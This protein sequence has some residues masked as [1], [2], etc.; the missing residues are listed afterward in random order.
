MTTETLKDSASTASDAG[1]GVN[2]HSFSAISTFSEVCSLQYRYRYLDRLPQERVS[3]ALVFGTAINAALLSIDKDLAKG[4]PPRAAVAH[5]V[6]RSE[7]EKAYGNRSLPVVSTHGEDLEGLYGKGVKMIDFHV[8]NLIPDEVPVDMPRRFT[9]P[10]LDEKGEA[11]PRPLV[12][13]LDRVVRLKDGSYGIVDWKTASARWSHDRIAK[14]DQATVYLL[15]G[16]YIL[17]GKVSFF[18]YDLLLKTVKPAIERYYVTRS[19]NETK[20]FIKKVLVVDKAI[21]SGVFTPN[22]R[23]FACPTC[24]YARTCA[25]WQD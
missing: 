19:D 7:L 16:K 24:P 14:D 10:L 9:I 6:L 22:D 21:Q 23:S 11:L 25:K 12:G 3:T 17:P 4:Q 20:R 8:E 1:E 2:H 15:A 13:E 18:R 5:Q